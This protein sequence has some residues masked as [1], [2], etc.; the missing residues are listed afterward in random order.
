MISASKLFQALAEGLSPRQKEVI[1]GRFGLEKFK[2]PQTLAALGSKYGVTRERVRQIEASALTD[3]RAKIG[4]DQ[5]SQDLVQRI[6][7]FLGASGGV[8]PQEALLAHTN[9]FSDGMTENHLNLFLEASRSFYRHPENKNFRPFYYLDKD[10]L[11]AA[12]AFLTQWASQLKNRK[13]EILKGGYA[14]ELASFVKK[15]GAANDHAETY[16]A[17]SK[18]IGANAYGDQ[19]LTE[20][21]EIQPR[22]V[23]DRIY[24]ALKKKNEPLHFR[25][26]AT[27]INQFNAKARPASAPTVHNELIK[28]SRFVLVGRGMY[29]LAEHGYEPGTAREVIHRVLKRNGALKPRDVM[30][31]VQKERFF[32]PNTILVNLQNKNFFRRQP[33]GTYKVRE[34]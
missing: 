23:R 9:T 8:A 33:D 12:N 5:A 25:S 4:K 2:E 32:K 3:L 27:I 31:A 18:R 21:P 24:L 26:I 10:S 6:R 30:L 34:A 22:T 7:K 1:T 28:D 14:A 15:S 20:W 13:E 29:G 17:I 19:G 11:K 16:L